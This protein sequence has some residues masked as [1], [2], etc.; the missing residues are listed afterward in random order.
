M[1]P[2]ISVIVPVYKVEA[3]LGRCVDSIRNQTW[4]NLE[5]ILVDDGS[6]DHSGALCDGYARQDS[7]IR[8]IHKPNGGLSSARNAGM[9]AAVGEYLAFVDSDD[10]I[11]PDMY[12]K[13]LNLMTRWDAQLACAGRYDVREETG[14]RKVGLCPPR[15]ECISGQ[16]LA[17]RIFL[18]DNCDSSA[19]DKLYRRELLQNLRYPDGR[20]C[21]D[22]PV[23]YRIALAAERAAMCPEPLYFYFHRKGSI[24]QAKEITDK[25]FHYSQNTQEIYPYIL[26]NYPEIAPQARFLRVHSL[27]HILLLLSQAD[28]AVRKN[29]R[30]EYVCAR[31]ALAKHTGFFLTYPRF[32]FQERVTDMLL[33]LGLYRL[34]RPLLHRS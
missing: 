4:K 5:I 29:Y 14:S 28:G 10:W 31:R 32:T 26:K 12:E 2:L 25:T 15:E 27:A 34:L 24:T 11:A 16:T 6:P 21:E 17:G 20:V 7:R 8:V 23:T 1:N 18:Y 13:L 22:M 9:A 3:Y 30:K 19:C 33:V